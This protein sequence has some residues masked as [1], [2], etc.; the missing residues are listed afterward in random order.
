MKDFPRPNCDAVVT[1]KM[2][3]EVKEQLKQKGKDAFFSPRRHYIGFKSNS[4]TQLAHLL[5]S[6]LISS[7]RMLWCPRKTL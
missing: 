6:G 1:P 7:T 4:W 2:D 3:E 5:V